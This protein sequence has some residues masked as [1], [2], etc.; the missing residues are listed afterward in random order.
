[1]P[2]ASTE[3]VGHLAFL[4]EIELHELASQSSDLEDV[5][6]ELTG[7]GRNGTPGEVVS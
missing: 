7:T 1:V 5:F 3:T 6:L 2:G 4:N